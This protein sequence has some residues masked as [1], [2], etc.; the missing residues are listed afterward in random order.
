MLQTKAPGIMVHIIHMLSVGAAAFVLLFL[1]ELGYLKWLHELIG[2]FCY[3]FKIRKENLSMD[4]DKK[5]VDND[6]Q[7]EKE[8]IS[9]LKPQDIQQFNLVMKDLSRNYKSFKAVNKL[10]L[11][12]KTHECFGLIGINGA[13]KTS[14]FKMLTGDLKMSGGEAWIRGIS[15]KTDMRK[16]HREIGYCP[17]FDALIEDLTGRQT[18]KFFALIRG[19][20][21][22]KIAEVCEKLS[23]DLNF[24]KHLDKPL[25]A[26][27]G[28]NKRKVSTAVALMGNPVIIF[29][30][31]PTSGEKL[32]RVVQ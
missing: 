6:V 5:S 27:S 22:N 18:L 30:D 20:P 17:Q 14:T 19:V 3:S 1:I 16:V 15:L 8:K 4:F 7:N 11:A 10:C 9:S 25:K 21:K 2:N 24:V 29:L 28:G 13:G 31:E 26:Y 23:T 32:I 12:I